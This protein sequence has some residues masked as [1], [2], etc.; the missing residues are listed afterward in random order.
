MYWPFSTLLFS[1]LSFSPCLNI[2][3]VITVIVTTADIPVALLVIFVAVD[4]S[5]YFLKK[6]N[7]NQSLAIILVFVVAIVIAVV[8]DFFSY[9]AGIKDTNI[10]VKV[11]N[12]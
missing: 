7:S 11:S 8:L 6:V 9:A 5:K 12:H 10:R 3:L 2:I 4:V 1:S